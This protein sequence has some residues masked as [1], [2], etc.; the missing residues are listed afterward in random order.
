MSGS[1]DALRAAEHPGCV[2]CGAG[3]PIGLRV[4][5]APRPDG[6]IQGTFQGAPAWEGYPGLLHG[7]VLSAL[8][9][10]AMTNCLFAQG[11]SAVTAELNVRY[12]ECVP[13]DQPLEIAAWLMRTR[14]RVHVLQA[15]IRLEGRVAVRASAKFMDR[16]HLCPAGE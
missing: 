15:E 2:V 3:N 9:D 5:F 14:G 6:G 1:F 7:G 4:E 10:G 11:L 16:R 13:V 8:L 12:V